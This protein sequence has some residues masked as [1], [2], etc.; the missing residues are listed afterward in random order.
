[1]SR[2]F[3]ACLSFFLAVSTGS[4]AVAAW[5]PEGVSLCTIGVCVPSGLRICSDGVGGA[6]VA[7]ADQRDSNYDVYLQHVLATGEIAPGWPATGF[8]VCTD[9]ANQ[10]IATIAAD[11]SDGV[12]IAWEDRRNSV[13]GGTLSDIYVQRVRSDGTLAG[14]WP[15]NGAV[16][17]QAP[18]SQAFP[19]LISDGNG[20]AYVTWDEPQTFTRDIHLQHL[21]A[22]GAVAPGWPTDGLPVCVLPGT[23]VEARL[24][25]DEG[26]GVFVAWND[27]R[28]GTLAAYVQRVLQDGNIAPGWPLNGTLVSP[29]QG[30]FALEPDAAGGAYIASAGV[31]LLDDFYLHRFTGSATIAPGWPA[32]GALVCFA[33]NDRAGLVMAPDGAGGALL[34][35]YDYRDYPD[36]IFLLR[37]QPNGSRHPAWPENGLRVTDNEEFDAGPFLAADGQGGAYLTWDRFADPRVMVQHITGT[38]GVAP[39]WPAG[40]YQIPSAVTATGERITEDG[41]GGAIVTWQQVDGSIR[42]LRVTPD[43]PT[44]VLVSLVSAEA[45]PGLVRLAWHAA[46]GAS[47]LATVERRTESSE[48]QRLG[49]L[50]AD[51]T[52]RLTYEDR[53][54]AAGTR[55]VYRLAYRDGA[56][57]AYTAE[58]WVDV[59]SLRFALRGLTPNPSSSDPVVAFSLASGER[60]TLELYDLG[61]R[62]VLSREVGGLGP[63]VHSV[64]LDTGGRLPSG[65]YTIRLRQGTAVA[66]VRAAIIR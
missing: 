13:P 43:S 10:F 12:L 1:M 56:D 37:M 34:A 16:A 19:F 21:T 39:G 6:F 40:G 54:V 36:E 25:L 33:P 60:A 41:L 5:P 31:P 7:W 47:L 22:A 11:E 20:G 46:D 57:I 18:I 8:P 26:G 61:G 35:W 17:S 44:A 27:S 51:G 32:G 23:Q 4:P 58:T 14:G 63:G 64:R 42:A 65:V 30:M 49:D 3:I 28:D 24:T 59:P 45:Q 38:A 55:Y 29:A 52:G 15:V 48:W 62:L 9:P 2:R 53:T 50:R 66:T